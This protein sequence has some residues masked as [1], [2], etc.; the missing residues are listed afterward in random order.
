MGLDPIGSVDYVDGSLGLFFSGAFHFTAFFGDHNFIWSFVI[1]VFLLK[2][3]PI[4]CFLSGLY[5]A[6][7]YCFWCRKLNSST[8]WER[9]PL[10]GQWLSFINWIFVWEMVCTFWKMACHGETYMLSQSCLV[11][12][13]FSC[14]LLILGEEGGGTLI[15]IFLNM[16]YWILQYYLIPVN[17]RK[18]SLD[19]ICSY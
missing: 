12:I 17:R 8:N 19:Y 9:F 4:L 15:L 10:R 13:C 7:K 11:L 6:W 18:Y 16:H 5:K 1:Y 2:W 14:K 3:G